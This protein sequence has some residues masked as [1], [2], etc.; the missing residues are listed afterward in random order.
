MRL[1]GIVV[2]GKGQARQ[3]GF[4]TANLQL[5]TCNSK[6]ATQDLCH[7]LQGISHKIRAGVYT[8]IVTVGDR[9]YRAAA[10]IG[11]WQEPN[12]PSLEA[13]LLDFSDDLLGQT[14]IVE[15]KKYLRPL[16]KF[17]SDEE[18]IKQ[19]E[20]DLKTIMSSRAPACR[21]AGSRGI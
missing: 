13:H 18:L 11:M 4:P 21:Q 20:L 3:L 12:G 16:K 1:T 15:L 9:Q 2:P 6:H 10:I 5:V 8:A 14:I 17:S 7:K 19:I